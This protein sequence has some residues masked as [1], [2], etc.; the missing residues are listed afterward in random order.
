MRKISLVCQFDI[1]FLEVTSKWMTLPI[2][3]PLFIIKSLCLPVFLADWYFLT[4][5]SST[6]QLSGWK[7]KAQFC[8]I[9]CFVAAREPILS[10][11]KSILG[12]FVSHVLFD[13]PLHPYVRIIRSKARCFYV[14]FPLF[15]WNSLTD[16]AKVILLD[17][18]Q[19]CFDSKDIEAG[20]EVWRCLAR[21]LKVKFDETILTLCWGSRRAQC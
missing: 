9:I 4:D 12:F 14:L 17:K 21:S 7:S 15:F 13:L 6:F 10:N 3:A 1:Q 2:K 18:T 20:V 5:F 8:P 16:P 11:L 19:I